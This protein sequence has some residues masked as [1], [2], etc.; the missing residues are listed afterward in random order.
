MNY[1]NN[2]AAAVEADDRNTYVS[3]S[4]AL[5]GVF[6]MAEAIVAPKG[7][8]GIEFTFKSVDGATANYLTL[9][10]ENVAGQAIWGYKQLCGIMTILGLSGA[11]SQVSTIKKYSK[12]ANGEIDTQATIYPDLINK[13]IGVLFQKEEYLSNS[14]EVK[15]RVNMY[16]FFNPETGATVMEIAKGMTSNGSRLQKVIES[17]KDKKL[18]AQS[19]A[20]QSGGYSNQPQPSTDFDDDLPY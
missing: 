6:T 1:Q 9:Y 7:T 19:S 2:T 16:G 17:I 12:E 10:T 3:E 20:Q 5:A 4:G 14:N 18:P 13:P 8:K 11:V 15:S